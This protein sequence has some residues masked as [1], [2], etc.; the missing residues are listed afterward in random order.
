MRPPIALAE[1]TEKEWQRQVVQLARQ[2]GYRVY[3][4]HLS[5][6]SQPGFP[7]LCCVRDRV[8]FVECKTETGKLSDPQSQWVE[9]LEKANALVIV[10]RPRDLQAV[11]DL[12]TKPVGELRAA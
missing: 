1:L 10:A 7:D 3:H 4:T 6:H 12:L 8:V 9:A 5:K 2:L 11:A